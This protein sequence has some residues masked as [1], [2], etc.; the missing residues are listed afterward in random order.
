[1]LS[2]DNLE[3][4]KMSDKFKTI[5]GDAIIDRYQYLR[6]MYTCLFEAS[7][8]GRTC[9]DPLLFHYPEDNEV[10]TN[11][12]HTFLVGDALKVSP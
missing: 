7:T 2:G 3:P 11:I 8:S 10:Y 9:F 4:W 6:H 5:A 12:E 1:L